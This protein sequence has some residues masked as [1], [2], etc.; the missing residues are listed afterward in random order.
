MVSSIRNFAR[1]LGSSHVIKSHAEKQR[2]YT[3]KRT[4]TNEQEFREL[5]KRLT[6]KL[7]HHRNHSHHNQH[8]H[9]QISA[10][11]NAKK[12]T[13]DFDLEQGDVD[14]E[15]RLHHKGS[16]NP[17]IKGIK[18]LRRVGSKQP[19]ILLMREEKDRFDAMRKI[20]EDTHKFKRYYALT[21][22]IIACKSYL[23]INSSKYRLFL[24]LYF[25]HL[26]SYPL[27]TTQS[28]HPLVRWRRWLLASR[29]KVPR[30]QLLRSPLLLLRFPP[31][32]RLRRPLPPIQRRQTPLR[33]LVSHRRPHHDHPHLRH[34][35]HRHRLLQTRHLQSR[36]LDRPPQRRPLA[37]P[38]R[39][40]SLA[41]PLA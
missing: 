29:A 40:L 25:L 21:M 32:H 8:Q 24:S 4:A 6:E 22:S 31:D 7:H 39:T 12:R 9:P 2:S 35:R 23:I 28:R 37:Q 16:K 18:M 20:Q 17:M 5:E 27:L 3:L 15:K 26:R 14:A 10:P 30:P 34:G 11:F 33:S 41:P 1:E 38:P 19:K 13:I 36:R